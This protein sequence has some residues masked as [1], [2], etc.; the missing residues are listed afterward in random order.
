MKPLSELSSLVVKP[1]KEFSETWK[2]ARSKASVR[3]IHDLR[4]NTRRMIAKLELTRAISG[5]EEIAGVQK[6]LK[7]VLTTS[8][9]SQ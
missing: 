8:L 6:Q 5:N 3:S 1:W 2:K 4:V 7:K 9:P